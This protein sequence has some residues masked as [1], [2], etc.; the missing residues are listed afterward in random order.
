MLG[1]ILA[2][3]LAVGGCSAR[4]S[5]LLLERQAR[6]PIMEEPAVGQALSWTL[7]PSPQTQI[8]TDIEITVNHATQGYLNDLFSNKAIFG[9][10]AGRSPY[11]PE[12]LVFYIKI[13]NRSK[14]KIR[15]IPTDFMLIDDRGN[16][17]SS[18][19]IDYVTAF[20]EYRKPVSTITRGMLENASPGYFGFSFPVGKVFANKP[21]GQFALLLQSSLQPGYLHPGVIHDG[22][23]AFWNPVAQSRKLRFLVTNIKTAFNAND[24][25]TQ[26]LE[27]S[28]DFDANPA[29]K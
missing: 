24:E 14:E 10:F 11:Y 26:T 27:F 15:I 23:I 13:A 2:G 21:Q 9:S 18:I 1:W 4:L 20:S 16:Q 12:H 8:Q 17:Y 29:T 25:P 19:G 6:G 7:D 3:V 5:S 28:F 22:L